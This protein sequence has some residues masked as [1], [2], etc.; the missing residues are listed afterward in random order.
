MPVSMSNV[1]DNEPVVHSQKGAYTVLLGQS[2]HAPASEI[3]STWLRW[4]GV[5]CAYGMCMFQWSAR[6]WSFFPLKSDEENLR[7]PMHGA[8]ASPCAKCTAYDIQHARTHA[9]TQKK[10]YTNTHSTQLTATPHATHGEARCRSERK[11]ECTRTPT[12]VA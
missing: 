9:R 8:V 12:P 3:V 4:G 6:V 11:H 5:G 2:M 10:K 7:W 1:G